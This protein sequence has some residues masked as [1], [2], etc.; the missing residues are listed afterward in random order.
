[1]SRRLRVLQDFL[2]NCKILNNIDD[3]AK[4]T[5][6]MAAES[7]HDLS[8]GDV[9]GPRRRTLQLLGI[10]GLPF[11]FPM[12]AG[13]ASA[14][15]QF[16][17]GRRASDALDDLEDAVDDLESALE[18]ALDAVERVDEDSDLDLD[19][20]D[21]AD[22]R[23]EEAQDH[24]DEASELVADLGRGFGR[25]G[26]GRRRFGR[27]AR[28][29]RDFGS[30][31]ETRDDAVDELRDAIDLMEEAIDL[32]GEDTDDGDDIDDLFEDAEDELDAAAEASD[33][34]DDAV[35]DARRARLDRVEDDIV[36]DVDR[37][38]GNV[39]RLIS[40]AQRNL[41]RNRPLDAADDLEDAL[42]WVD[43]AQNA[44]AD[45]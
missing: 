16:G 17:D 14:T 40:D 1:M 31:A 5:T 22:D 24:L 44:L 27:G 28:A 29:D 10:A 41:D 35:S 32:L 13:R 25:R 2:S 26:F 19:A 12:S 33:D 37:A 4:P 45:L 6:F 15:H 43:L 7:A 38:N 11:A 18:D 34:V 20:I 23:I 42:D 21:E 30:R 3:S 8:V 39:A 36:D 9:D